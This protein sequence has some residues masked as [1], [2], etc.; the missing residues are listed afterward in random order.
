[1][2]FSSRC[3]CLF[4]SAIITAATIGS[5]VASPRLACSV[6]PLAEIESI[7]GNSL[8]VGRAAKARPE[9]DSTHSA[10]G[11]DP[12]DRVGRGLLFTLITASGPK[13]AEAQSQTRADPGHTFG[14]TAI[15]GGMFVSARV[16]DMKG[17][18]TDM[19]MSEKVLAA[20]LRHL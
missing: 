10:C 9:R 7:V 17:F 8:T 20:A 12:K 4:T 16:I 6:L 2:K 3:V 13:L 5:A 18:T 14:A 15:K 19:A 11:Y 1:M